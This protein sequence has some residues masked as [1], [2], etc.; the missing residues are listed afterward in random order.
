MSRMLT[1]VEAQKMIAEAVS[2]ASRAPRPFKIFGLDGSK[3]YAEAVAGHLGVKVTPH[4]EKTFD[5]GEPYAKSVDGENGNVRGHN[6]FVIQSLYSDEQESVCDKFVKLC[7]MCGSLNDASAHEV[8][9][10]IPH[11]AFARQDRKTHSREP[12]TTKYVAR[13][14]E[15]CGVARCLFVDVH[16]L[17]AEQNAFRVPID[18]LEAKNLHADWCARQLIAS[19]RTKKIRVLVPD[20]GGLNRGERFRNSLLKI[21]NQ[22]G[23]KVDDIEIVIFDKLRKKG[24]IEGRRIIGDVEDADVIGYDDMISTGSTMKKSCQAVLDFKGRLFAICVTHGIFC[25]EANNVFDSLD[26]H[27]VVA[28]TVQPFRLNETNRKK[29]HFV[30]TSKMVADAIRRIHSGNGSVSEL[31]S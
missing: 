1:E 27:I 21:L 6:V 22:L 25:G 8:T 14:L 19:G 2:K 9:A 16:N 5:D 12:I 18:N 4:D 24:R 11:L 10:V 31:L 28:D 30:E 20:S 29:I 3:S 15:A 13:M 23:A 7:I 17:A 26:T